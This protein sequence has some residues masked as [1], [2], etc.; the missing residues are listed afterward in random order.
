VEGHAGRTAGILQRRKGAG[1]RKRR[2]DPRQPEQSVPAPGKNVEIAAADAE[3]PAEP[4]PHQE[5]VPA[6]QRVQVVAVRK[7]EQPTPHVRG[8]G[9][10]VREPGEM[11]DKARRSAF[12]EGEDPDPEE[13]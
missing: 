7:V 1:G 3:H 2:R 9:R 12:L 10:D 11:R 4:F 5:D 6:A 13:K 8:D